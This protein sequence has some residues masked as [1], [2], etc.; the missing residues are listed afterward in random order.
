MSANVQPVV[1]HDEKSNVFIFLSEIAYGKPRKVVGL[2][3]FKYFIK[4][5]KK[6]QSRH[7][8]MSHQKHPK[9]SDSHL[10][11]DFALFNLHHKNTPV[12]AWTFIGEVFPRSR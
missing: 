4:P 8:P 3:F 2:F 7:S 10:I 1:A 9:F 12:G 6:S 5:V 11:I